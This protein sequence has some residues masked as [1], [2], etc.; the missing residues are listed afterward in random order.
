MEGSPME[1][2][3]H[4]DCIIIDGIAFRAGECIENVTDKFKEI[5]SLMAEF[6]NSL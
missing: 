5:E 2:Y 6:Q 4:E 1:N 3:T